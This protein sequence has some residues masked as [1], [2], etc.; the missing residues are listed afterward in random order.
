[1]NTQPHM[2]DAAQTRPDAAQGKPNGLGKR[3]I[4]ASALALG[5]AVLALGALGLYGIERS[6]G[7]HVAH[8][9]ACA[10]SL[11]L[12]SAAD[13]LVHGEIAALTLANSPHPLDRISFDDGDGMRT[14]L[15]SFKGKTV[16]LNLWAT[17]CV[18]CRAEM[19]SLDKLQ[20]QM[21][22]DKF[23]VV[24]VNIDTV[25][26]DKPRAFLKE[27]GATSL[28]FYADPT[29]DILQNLKSDIAIVGL[30]TTILIGRDGCEIGAMAGPAEWDSPD[31]KALIQRLEQSSTPRAQT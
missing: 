18:P 7:K 16:L 10:Q 22:S 8:A 14:T 28:P 27:I 9:G 4:A 25:R 23:S 20:A 29:A 17:W 3:R 15:A 6:G 30:P 13:P 26:L 5:V 24:P 11:D 21:G 31:A 1:M 12:A 2:P 19:P